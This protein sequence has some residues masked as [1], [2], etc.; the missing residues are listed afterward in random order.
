MKI[1]LS[2]DLGLFT[3]DM[4]ADAIFSAFARHNSYNWTKY[5]LKLKLV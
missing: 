2:N 1:D 5:A 4:R 3:N